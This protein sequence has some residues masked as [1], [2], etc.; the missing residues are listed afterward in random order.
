M[1]DFIKG[2]QGVTE[3]QLQKVVPRDGENFGKTVKIFRIVVDGV[4]FDWSINIRSPMYLQVLQAAV[5]P[6]RPSTIGIVY[7]AASSVP[8]RA[9]H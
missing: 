2:E 6:S 8:A 3:F 1:K 9:P 7:P 4:E 5:A